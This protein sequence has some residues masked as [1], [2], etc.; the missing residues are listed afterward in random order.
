MEPHTENTEMS[1][2]VAPSSSAP[3]ATAGI[4]GPACPS[5]G[6]E[7]P[8]PRA[9]LAARLRCPEAACGARLKIRG[10]R[11]LAV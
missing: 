3:F 6:L 1:T 8:L 11:A 9:V 7:L 10:G 2:L 5:C 4:T